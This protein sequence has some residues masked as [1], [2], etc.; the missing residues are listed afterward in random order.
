MS[1]NSPLDM[2]SVVIRT[3]A[4]ITVVLVVGFGTALGAQGIVVDDAGA[5]SGV[6]ADAGHDR[7]RQAVG[8]HAPS[9]THC[10][11]GAVCLAALLPEPM[12]PPAP[13]TGLTRFAIVNFAVPSAPA[14][15]L[16]R[17]PQH[18]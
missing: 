8:V 12:L 16:L 17:P 4:L 13:E 18:S 15:G 7:S 3:L 2:S 6:V 9:A 1:H 5:H 10:G 11:G 14:F